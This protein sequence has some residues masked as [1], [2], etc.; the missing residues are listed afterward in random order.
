[1]KSDCHSTGRCLARAAALVACLVVGVTA[2]AALPIDKLQLPPGFRIEVLSD[3]VPNARQMAL[4]RNADGKGVVYVGSTQAGKVYA[5][6]YG[7]SGPAMVKTIASGLELPTG[8]AYR[9]GK[10]YVGALARIL[11]FDAI[12]DHLGAPPAPVI[13]S[14]KFPADTHHGRR[15]LAF[16][17]DGKLY[18]PVGA[19]CN[20]CLPDDRHGVIQRMNADG[21][22]L[23]TVARGVRNSVGFDWNPR[24]RTL[25]FTD[26]GRD[27][28]GDDLPSRRAR[29]C[30]T[31]RRAFRLSVLP[32]GRLA[33]PEF[34][35]GTP[36]ASSR[37]R[38]P[39]SVPT[40]PRS[41]CASTAARSSRRPTAAT[42][43]SPSTARGIAAGRA[44]T[45]S[46]ASHRRRRPCRHAR[47]VR[48]RLAA[49]RRRRPRDRLGPAGR[50]AAAARRVFARQR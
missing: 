9:D 39:S 8:V 34:G 29:S 46:R 38:P 32:P 45:W 17:P 12:D 40:S 42:P 30:R 36:A 18:V 2:S 16:G 43:S 31:Q 28:L 1:M 37:R 14:D 5:V 49:G 3:A 11:R 21:S 35:A 48:A 19:P 15:F 24:D 6:E 22:G 27:M 26:N 10:L 44:A 4:G 13:V 7:A 47:A 50:R 23:E 25:W 33:D 41:A 20:I